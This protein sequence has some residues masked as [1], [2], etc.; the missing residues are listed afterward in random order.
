MG[1]AERFKRGVLSN[2]VTV[3][4][5]LCPNESEKLMLAISAPCHIVFLGGRN[6]YA[7]S[8]ERGCPY[9]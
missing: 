2:P 4:P 3:N 1:G 9:C 7:I 5:E 6:G 8:S